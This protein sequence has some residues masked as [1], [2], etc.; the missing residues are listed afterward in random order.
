VDRYS[1][2]DFTPKD[3]GDSYY[4]LPAST[5]H[6]GLDITAN[7]T[8]ETVVGLISEGI[9]PRRL[10]DADAAAAV[11]GGATAASDFHIPRTGYSN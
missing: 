8:E 11:H 6:W 4:M 10:G 1:V 7:M 9:L 2:Y 3:G 5:D